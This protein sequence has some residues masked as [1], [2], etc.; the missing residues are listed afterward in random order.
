MSFS[1]ASLQEQDFSLIQLSDPATGIRTKILPDHGALLQEFSMPVKGG[2][3]QAVTGYHNL[4]DLKQHHALFYRSAKLSP[5]PCRI[6]DGRYYFDGKAY[7]FRHKF[8]DGSAI[9]GLL[10]DK[11]FTVLETEASAAEASVLLEYRYHQED[12]GYP[13]DY[14]INVKYTLKP[15][16]RLKLETR[17]TNFSDLRIPM[18]D[19]W[20]PY[21]SLGGK[22]DDWTLTIDAR[23]MLFLNDRLVPTGEKQTQDEF[24]AGARI[25]DFRFDHC[26]LLEFDPDR[27]ACRLYN[28]QNRAYLSLFPDKSYPYLQVYSPD[29]RLSLAIENL[30]AAPD[31]FNNGIG[32]TLLEPKHSQSFTTVYQIGL[33]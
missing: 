8:P 30:S 32:V 18:A 17:V 31:S 10:A 29:D 12:P 23:T 26:F 11:P 6:L 25:S 5:F 9:H 3:L 33:D 7:E 13:F 24:Y 2:R 28:P 4:A 1:I 19:G 21:F 27:P 14:K 16:G 22:A 15:E 20:H